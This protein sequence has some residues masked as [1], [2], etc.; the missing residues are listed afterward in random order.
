[1]AGMMGRLGARGAQ[2]EHP[3][4]LRDPLLAEAASFSLPRSSAPDGGSFMVGREMEAEETARREERSLGVALSH[5]TVEAIHQGKFLFD[6][7]LV[8]MIVD[9]GR[10]LSN[11]DQY[12]EKAA[13]APEGAAKGVTAV[14]GDTSMETVISERMTE[15]LMGDLED[16][17]HVIS[18]FNVKLEFLREYHELNFE[19]IVKP[20]VNANKAGTGK[21]KWFVKSSRWALSMVFCRSRYMRAI[22]RKTGERCLPRVTL[23]HSMEKDRRARMYG[24][25]FDTFLELSNQASDFAF[26]I[27]KLAVVPGEFL[28][29]FWI[30][31][32]ALASSY[33]FKFY[34]GYSVRKQVDWKNPRRVQKYLIGLV[35]SLLEPTSGFNTF[36]K[37]SF[38]D[39]EAL[40]QNII[41]ESSG[42]FLKDPVA[43]QAKADYK[44]AR[45]SV[46]QTFAIFLQDIPQLIVEILYIAFFSNGN[47]QYIYWFALSTTL[48]HIFRQLFEA[49]ML[50]IDI[51]HLHNLVNLRHLVMDNAPDDLV[52]VAPVDPNNPAFDATNHDDE[53]GDGAQRGR[54]RRRRRGQGGRAKVQETLNAFFDN[55]IA[56]GRQCCWTS[57]AGQAFLEYQRVLRPA[58]IKDGMLFFYVMET[59]KVNLLNPF[60]WDRCFSSA[61]EQ[62]RPIAVGNADKRI[63]GILFNRMHARTLHSSIR[64][65]ELTD[66]VSVDGRV[67]ANIA[68][69][70]PIL[71]RI[72]L[73]FCD[74]IDD[75]A[76]L[77]MRNAGTPSLE[78]VVLDS[79][80]RVTDLGVRY[81]AESTGANLLRISMRNMPRVG[82]DALEI[83]GALCWNLREVKID[84]DPLLKR[85]SR[86]E[87]AERNGSKEKSSYF[88]V[89]GLTAF[90]DGC[91][92]RLRHLQIGNAV[93]DDDTKAT[94]QL[95]A[96]LAKLNPGVRVLAFD[97]MSHFD[98]SILAKLS[99]KAHFLRELHLTGTAI[100][101]D[102]VEELLDFNSSLKLLS[103][104]G[105]TVSTEK[106]DEAWLRCNDLQSVAFDNAVELCRFYHD[107]LCKHI[108]R[109]DK[110]VEK[111]AKERPVHHI[112]EELEEEAASLLSAIR[113]EVA[114]PD[115]WD[116]VLRRIHAL[117]KRSKDPDSSEELRIE[118]VLKVLV[119]FVDF[120]RR[121][122]FRLMQRRNHSY[123]AVWS[124]ESNQG[125][126]AE[127]LKSTAVELDWFREVQAKGGSPQG[128]VALPPVFPPRTVG[129]FGVASTRKINLKVNFDE[130]RYTFIL[131]RRLRDGIAELRVERALEG[132]IS[133]LTSL[134][135]STNNKLLP[136]FLSIPGTARYYCWAYPIKWVDADFASSFEQHRGRDD[137]VQRFLSFGGY[138]YFDE[139]RH[140]VSASALTVGAALSFNGP[141]SMT[142]STI[143]TLGKQSRWQPVTIRAMVPDGMQMDF[144]FIFPRET[145]ID[146][147]LQ[148]INY[149]GGFAYRAYAIGAKAS[150]AKGCFFALSNIPNSIVDDVVAVRQR[151]EEK[152]LAKVIEMTEGAGTAATT[153][154][155]SK[156]RATSAIS[157][158][159]AAVADPAAPDH[160]KRLSKEL[161][162][163]IESDADAD[164]SSTSDSDGDVDEGA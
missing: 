44:A 134:S 82:D 10:R 141:F 108:K 128:P 79:C 104:D 55:E 109:L 14:A 85:L 70:C 118:L 41:G 52:K 88:T 33:L 37:R 27:L 149:H 114:D 74:K 18:K 153:V 29:L 31:V 136:K 97:G 121:N 90:V 162:I 101:D 72:D 155:R 61:K 83:L 25:I 159:S 147:H 133:P 146:P 132:K 49:C 119:S 140:F 3:A 39:R 98:D 113:T 45:M 91:G 28:Y 110:L 26:I 137:V 5:K 92:R 73:S 48:F 59:K 57:D 144:C 84:R 71:R 47:F 87:R 158:G 53:N 129:P 46:L 150:T 115:S 2:E 17:L 20:K 9:V 154:G 40:G 116:R 124:S 36:I 42:S 161:S 142:G 152:A 86:R 34:I 1:M 96:M 64:S 21:F 105:T 94:A 112:D 32:G 107:Q 80:I 117:R 76:L 99:R 148:K 93:R 138:L 16:F 58:V 13:R 103:L 127:E 100:T 66:C 63:M 163:I 35:W 69:S 8:G 131:P 135:L 156:S 11:L 6:P 30:S 81:L 78:S 65:L 111:I 77:G 125:L 38:K 139:A 123:A 12:C 89:K 157:A 160:A 60:N 120:V 62:R 106:L 19:E 102:G 43:T 151:K 122:R 164:D 143:S 75:Q 24:T 95:E 22:E 56:V 51:P 130:E 50:L 4:R 7:A 23:P 145:S 126:R 54:R 68:R 67:L 15:V